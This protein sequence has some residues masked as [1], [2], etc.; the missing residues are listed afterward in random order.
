VHRA[1]S[2][3]RAFIFLAV[4]LNVSYFVFD[5]GGIL[6]VAIAQRLKNIPL[7][8]IHE[9]KYPEDLSKYD[10]IIKLPSDLDAYLV[11]AP[12]GLA[13]VAGLSVFLLWKNPALTLGSGAVYLFC[14]V[15]LI[16][17]SSVNLAYGREEMNARTQGILDAT[18]CLFG[19]GAALILGGPAKQKFKNA[20]ETSQ[21]LSLGGLFLLLFQGVALPGISAILWSFDSL[22]TEE[23]VMNG[24]THNIIPGGLDFFCA[25][26][27]L[28]L[29]LRILVGKVAPQPA[30]KQR[31]RGSWIWR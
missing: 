24:Q 5:Y 9:A 20:S 25:L 23:I 4:S 13:L 17:V 14:M 16:P 21:F 29:A 22:W 12:I 7:S 27:S 11:A 19:I 26:G 15:F 18:M 30:D 31:N 6:G 1:M 28:M 3:L 10:R 2:L 8:K